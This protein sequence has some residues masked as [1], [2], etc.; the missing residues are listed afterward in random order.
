MK[1]FGASR[2]IDTSLDVG[3]AN[4][5]FALDY[6]QR[7]GLALAGQ[8]LGGATGRRIHF[9]PTTGQAFRRMLRPETE[10]ETLHREMDYLTALKRTP[11]EGEMELF[12]RR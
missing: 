8:D 5:A 4:A 10:R 6:V 11:V 1:L 3:S 7:E 12:D 2:V 9:F